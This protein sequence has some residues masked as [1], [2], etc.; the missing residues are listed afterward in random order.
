ML[1]KMFQQ[2]GSELPK[3]PDYDNQH[4]KQYSI[5]KRKWPKLNHFY[6]NRDPVFLV[7]P[8]FVTQVTECLCS[9]WVFS[10]AKF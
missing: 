7:V 4:A 5:L 2:W 1:K 8:T 3:L 9:G 6:L 10:S